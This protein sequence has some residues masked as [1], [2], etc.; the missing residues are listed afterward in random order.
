MRGGRLWRGSWRRE[1]RRKIDYEAFCWLQGHSPRTKSSLLCVNR[2][3]VL[4]VRAHK[5]MSPPPK[6]MGIQEP[7]L[8][9]NAARCSYT[10][11][12]PTPV[13]C[14]RH[15]L[16]RI[17]YVCSNEA[18]GALICTTPFKASTQLSRRVAPSF[19]IHEA[20]TSFRSSVPTESSVSP[21]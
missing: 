13:L 8:G 16:F 21:A 6:S 14:K 5:D 7:P 19:S 4:S 18:Q 2:K 1:R 3:Y 12:G 17:P 11:F 10:D 15:F 20:S 9:V